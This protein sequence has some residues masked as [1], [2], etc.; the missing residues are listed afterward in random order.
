MVYVQGRSLDL[1]LEGED[2]HSHCEGNLPCDHNNFVRLLL[3][4]YGNNLNTLEVHS[5]FGDLSMCV[6]LH[7]HNNCICKWCN[8]IQLRFK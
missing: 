2:D 1:G 4:T 7:F 3:Y 6:I 8:S 5:L